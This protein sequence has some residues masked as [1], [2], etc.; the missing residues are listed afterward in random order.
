MYGCPRRGAFI[1]SPKTLYTR[2]RTWYHI[3]GFDRYQHLSRDCP[4]ARE[5][6]DSARLS[7]SAY[8]TFSLKCYMV[9]KALANTSFL[10]RTAA[11]KTRNCRKGTALAFREVVAGEA[12][13]ETKT[14]YVTF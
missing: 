8:V 6:P 13:N 2:R 9:E 1:I 4:P 10:G 12:E 3:E 11:R 14:A 7:S 5:R